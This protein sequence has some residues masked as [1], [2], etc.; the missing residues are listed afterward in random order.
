LHTEVAEKADCRPLQLDDRRARVLWRADDSEDLRIRVAAR[1][2][3]PLIPRL[4]ASPSAHGAHL[5][6]LR[7]VILEFFDRHGLTHAA[8]SINSERGHPRLSQVSGQGAQM[9]KD[10]D[11]F[12]IGDPTAPST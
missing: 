7:I 5:G 3:D 8:V 9:A 10:L 6:C 1:S 2:V 12:G 4:A 11:R